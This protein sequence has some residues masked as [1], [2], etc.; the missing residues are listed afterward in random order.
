MEKIL[1]VAAVVAVNGKKP[2]SFRVTLIES[3][4]DIL[5]L[6]KGDKMA[7]TSDEASRKI[8]IRKAR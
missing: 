6:K 7:F 1:G 5:E 8:Q 2:R 3:V 4:V